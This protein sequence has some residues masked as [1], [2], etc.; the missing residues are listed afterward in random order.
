MIVPVYVSHC[1]SPDRERLV[2]ALLDKQSGTTFVLEDTCKALGVSGTEV[3]LSLSTMYAANKVVTSLK[4]KGKRMRGINDGPRI[5]LPHAYTGSIVPANH[6]H[7]P[8]SDIARMWPHLETIADQKETLRDCEIGLLIGYNCPTALTSREVISASNEDGPYGLRTDLG[9]SIVGIVDADSCEDP[10]GLSHRILSQEVVSPCH[11]DEDTKPSS[12]LFLWKPKLKKLWLVMCLESWNVILVISV[13]ATQ[14]IL[15]KIKDLFQLCLKEFI[16]KVV[17]MKYLYPFR[18]RVY[19]F[20]T[21]GPMHWTGWSLCEE[22]GREMK[23]TVSITLSSRR[24]IWRIVMRKL[25]REPTAITRDVMKLFHQFKVNSNHGDYLRFQWWSDD[26]YNKEHQEYR[27]TVHLFGATSKP[28]CENFGFKRI[29]QDYQDEFGE[30]AAEFK[31]R[32]FYVDD[33]LKKI[34]R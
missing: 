5:S 4:V 7:I 24:N 1:D 34:K 19:V 8:T 25:F 26:D 27:M 6:E 30:E 33:G 3:R 10:I 29:A 17:I 11:T 12:I 14:N 2:Y 18:V 9:W 20:Q 21:T 13:S 23:L 28:G 32:D 22:D 31:R 15:K 16:L